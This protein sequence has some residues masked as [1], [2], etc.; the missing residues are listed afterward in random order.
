LCTVSVALL[1]NKG[2]RRDGVCNPVTYVLKA[3]EV[4][5]RFGRGCKPRPAAAVSVALL[6]NKGLRRD[7][8]CNPVTY[9]L[10]AVEAF[11]RFGRGCKTRPAAFYEPNLSLFS[12][13]NER[14][15]I[16]R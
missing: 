16:L 8:V 7:G 6:V 15:L 13:K 2:L 10:K 5:K 14:C 4:F 11:K 1:V 3:V 9:V 12:C